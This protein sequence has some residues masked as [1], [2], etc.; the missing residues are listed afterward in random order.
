VEN[1]AF[2]PTLDGQGAVWLYL[3]EITRAYLDSVSQTKGTV[4]EIAAG[5][6]HVVNQALEAGAAKVFANEIDAAQ[7]SIIQSRVPVANAAQL[8]CRLGQFPEHLDFPDNS[9]DAIYSARLIHFFDGDRIRASMEKLFRWLKSYGKVFLVGDTVY[10]SI[11]ESLIP[12]Y[13]RQLAAGDEWPG[14]IPDVR[15]CIPERLHPEKFPKMMNFLDPTMLS[16]ELA[17]AGF[18]VLTANFYPY[19]GT[20]T[21]GRLD[22]R[23]LA[24][25][26]ALKP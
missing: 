10:R 23:E 26:L 8:V 4:L 6:G 19:T 13:Q 22:G 20:F 21:P 14:L 15:S 5:Y 1:N 2:I 24:G 16:R 11:F 12:I 3:D 18:N 7:L 25:A 9:F 17:L